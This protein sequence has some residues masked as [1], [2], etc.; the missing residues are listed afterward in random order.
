MQEG[1]E[2][3]VCT[4]SPSFL[5]AWIPLAAPSMNALL[6]CIH[7]R[8]IPKP[9]I[10]LFRSNFKSYLPKWCLATTGPFKV[11]YDF[12][13]DWFTKAG[14]PRKKDVHNLIKSCDDAWVDRYGFDDA[15]IWF[16]SWGKI[17]SVDKVGIQVR[18][19]PFES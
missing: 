3:E 10:R 19:S 4:A 1:S 11:H 18:I 15:L 12:Y 16:G 8:H 13:E 5:T 7:G 2:G 17:Q 9:E 6:Y 14:F